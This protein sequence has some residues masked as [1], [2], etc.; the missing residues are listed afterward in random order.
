MCSPFVRCLKEDGYQRRLALGFRRHAG[1]SGYLQLCRLIICHYPNTSVIYFMWKIVY[2]VHASSSLS[3]ELM[4]AED[5]W[6]LK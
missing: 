3:L 6:R 1:I 2:D 5:F 4:R